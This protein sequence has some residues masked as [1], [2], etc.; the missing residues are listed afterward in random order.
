MLRFVQRWEESSV[1]HQSNENSGSS[2]SSAVQ[3]HA[4]YESV[5]S[6]NR[7]FRGTLEQCGVMR[8]QV[9]FLTKGL[10]FFD[11][12]ISTTRTVAWH[13]ASTYCPGAY[14]GTPGRSNSPAKWQ[15]AKCSDVTSFSG[16]SVVRQI[17]WTKGQRGWK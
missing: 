17:S 6:P 13:P 12:G 10:I 8:R 14:A 5:T 9:M 4:D 1:G 3:R 15:L 16:G 2:Q 7:V 11:R